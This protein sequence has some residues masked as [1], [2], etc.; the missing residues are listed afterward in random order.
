MPLLD[1]RGVTP[2]MFFKLTGIAF[3]GVLMTSVLVDL[4]FLRLS[5]GL[6]FPYY[7][8]CI[9]FFA[10]GV[11]SFALRVSD[12]SPIK[13]LGRPVSVLAILLLLMAIFEEMT[14]QFRPSRGFSYHDMVANVVGILTFA[15][16]ASYVLKKR[17]IIR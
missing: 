7:D 16:L 9:H 4:G 11:A 17:W 3:V 8:V 2:S 14:Q 6:K 10:T 13:I 12:R 15:W 5:D 1:L